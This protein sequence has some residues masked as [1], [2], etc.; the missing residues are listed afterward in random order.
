MSTSIIGYLALSA[1]VKY[2]LSQSGYKKRPHNAKLVGKLSDILIYPVKKMRR[3]EL[4]SAEC[5]YSGLVADGYHDRY[6]IYS[7]HFYIFCH[8]L[9]FSLLLSEG[10]LNTTIS[11]VD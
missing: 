4:E 1:S 10:P 6:I 11:K 7:F 9:C 8:L 5:R 2:M 3:V